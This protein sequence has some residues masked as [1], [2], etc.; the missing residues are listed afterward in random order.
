MHEYNQRML[1][2]ILTGLMA[3]MPWSPTRAETLPLANN[4]HAFNCEAPIRVMPLGDSITRGSG[5]PDSTGYR[6]PLFTNLAGAGYSVDFVGAERDGGAAPL[7]FDTEHYGFSGR[8][9]DWIASQ[10]E[11]FLNAAPADVILLH[12]GTNDLLDGQP[13]SQV[14]DEVM[15]ILD[16]ID[17]WENSHSAVTVLL[18]QIINVPGSNAA[19]SAFNDQLQTLAQ[20]RIANGD[21]IYL[22]DI[23]N[24][25]GLDYDDDSIDFVDEVHPSY[26]GYQKVANLWLKTV[27]NKLNWPLCN[28]LQVEMTIPS[29]IVTSSGAANFTVRI[30]NDG[31][32]T[33]SNLA[34]SSPTA[35]ACAQQLSDLKAGKSTQF[36]CTAPNVTSG[37][38]H[39]VTVTA[40][41]PDAGQLANQYTLYITARLANLAPLVDLNGLLQGGGDFALTYA[42][43]AGPQP[44][45]APDAFISD[46]DQATYVSATITPVEQPDGAAESIAVDTTNTAIRANYD[47]TTGAI[48]LTG[49]DS[50]DKFWQVLR[51]AV[52][53]NKSQNPAASLRTIEFSVS[54]G[55]PDRNVSRT[56]I[57]VVPQNDA[58]VIAANNGLLTLVGRTT[59]LQPVHL[60]AADPD[61]PAVDLTFTLVEAP[62]HGQLLLDET[63][64]APGDTFGQ[65]DL[66]VR[67]IF[68][69]HTGD[70]PETDSFSFRVT[71]TDGATTSVES[72]PIMVMDQI[73][74]FL[75]IAARS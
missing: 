61:H 19:I 4:R 11:A 37:F 38:Q 14:A 35:P 34:I 12:I 20:S 30:L 42:E 69:R 17:Q 27:Q 29:S 65:V 63:T 9:A 21:Q 16:A 62:A 60:R 23:E 41:H 64:L 45:T 8:T 26:A 7:S 39:Y 48:Q 15:D 75:P 13:P 67:R 40:T 43:D 6:L 44:I 59:A 68:Y 32:K 36:S 2:I 31:A 57:T 46:P 74:L 71:D 49:P 18:A 54:D 10:V 5:T 56:L 25:A 22:V 28:V 66:D 55:S 50:F 47:E 53:T 52:Y 58:P 72:L 24:A 33:I 1:M 73:P 3:W 51:S 70:T